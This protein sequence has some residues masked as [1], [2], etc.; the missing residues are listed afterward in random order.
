MSLS[1]IHLLGRPV[2]L[3]DMSSITLGVAY[4][5]AHSLHSLYSAA[6]EIDGSLCR[7]RTKRSEPAEG[8]GKQLSVAFVLRCSISMPT[9]LL[10]SGFW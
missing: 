2:R 10:Q 5:L 3:G 8:S 9:P 1:L 6:L 4:Q 7:N